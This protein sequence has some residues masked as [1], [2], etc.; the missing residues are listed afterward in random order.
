MAQ[1]VRDLTQP[2]VLKRKTLLSTMICEEIRW[3]GGR[4][5]VWDGDRLSFSNRVGN[6]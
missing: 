5:V 2:R 6:S 4:V 1:W 3:M